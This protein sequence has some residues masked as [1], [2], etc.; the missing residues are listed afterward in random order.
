MLIRNITA[1][2]IEVASDLE[3]LKNQFI[4]KIYGNLSLAFYKTS[5]YKNCLN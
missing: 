3:D 5:D 2:N 4:L 1:D